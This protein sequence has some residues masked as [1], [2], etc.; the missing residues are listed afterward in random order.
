MDRSEAA[1]VVANS[2]WIYHEGEIIDREL[3]A[4]WNKSLSEALR[5][6]G[7]NFMDG[8]T[9]ASP[10]TAGTQFSVMS[11]DVDIVEPYIPNIE[12]LKKDAALRRQASRLTP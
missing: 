10:T 5:V 3:Q 4:M 9:I 2:S 8:R 12:Q 6:L 7:V 1:T 11:S